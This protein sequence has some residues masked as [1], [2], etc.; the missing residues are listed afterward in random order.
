[1]KTQN[2]QCV[3]LLH[4]LARTAHAMKKMANALENTGYTVVNQGYP[5]TKKDIQTL[6][7][8][9]LP[10]ALGKCP[11]TG[12]IHFVTHS[13]GGILLRQYLSQH[14]IE[15]MGRTVMLGP[16]NQ[17]LSLIHI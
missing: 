11:P 5:S 4:G 13:M 14:T 2:P 17:G 1:M 16:P 12:T 15:R 8:E 10:K 3:I 6:A 9:T 7:R